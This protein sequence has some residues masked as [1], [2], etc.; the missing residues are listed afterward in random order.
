[1]SGV[2]AATP[3]LPDS[4]WSYGRVVA[5]EEA[6]STPASAEH[7]VRRTM[8]LAISRLDDLGIVVY[9]P[10]SS[11]TTPTMAASANP[12]G[13]ESPFPAQA[14][15][16]ARRER[17]CAATGSSNPET[18]SASVEGSGVGVSANVGLIAPATSTSKESPG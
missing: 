12:V 18:N 17:S 4:A 2:S 7:N 14:A 11:S 9:A 10:A 15:Y 1:M 8:E 3:A 6:H 5:I 16:T 13:L